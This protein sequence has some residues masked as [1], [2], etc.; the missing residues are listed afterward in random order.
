MARTKTKA[1]SSIILFNSLESAIVDYTSEAF[2]GYEQRDIA[3]LLAD[4]LERGRERLDE[5][6]KAIKDLL[7]PV[8]E[9]KDYL[10]YKDF[11][12]GVLLD[13]KAVASYEPKRIALYRCT[14]GYA[15]AY[16]NLANDMGKAG[17]SAGDEAA[18][19]T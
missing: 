12:I 13:Q 5:A 10:D 18:I 7:E 4:W 8:A 1:T 11:F 17:Y 15:R 9:H 14:D 19:K 6:R 3:G 16:A 2:S